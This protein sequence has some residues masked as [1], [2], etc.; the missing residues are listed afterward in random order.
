MAKFVRSWRSLKLKN[1][2]VEADIFLSPL[3]IKEAGSAQKKSISGDVEP[4]AHEELSLCGVAKSILGYREW[5][6]P[7]HAQ[8]QF[9]E[10]AGVINTEGWC[11]GLSDIFLEN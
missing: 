5:P 6:R 9:V 3:A 10:G 11:H 4:T 8:P 7:V 2:D 1:I